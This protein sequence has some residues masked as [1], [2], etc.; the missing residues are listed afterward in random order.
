MVKHK[1]A[2]IKKRQPRHEEDVIDFIL[3]DEALAEPV[4]L[5]RKKKKKAA[6]KSKKKVVKKVSK[7]SR[8]KKAKKRA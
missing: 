1:K 3:F 2:A 6:A 7:K 4:A 5:K 8:K